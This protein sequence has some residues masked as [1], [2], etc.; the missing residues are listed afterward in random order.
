MT[1]NLEGAASVNWLREKDMPAITDLAEAF[2]RAAEEDAIASPPLK[3]LI[4][5]ADQVTIIISD[6]TRYWTRQDKVPPTPLAPCCPRI[7]WT[8][9]FLLGNKQGF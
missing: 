8:P 6:I 2:R 3:E 9:R 7:S 4:G 1:L 5:P